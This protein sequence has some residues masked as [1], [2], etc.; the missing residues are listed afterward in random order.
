MKRHLGVAASLLLVAYLTAAD[1]SAVVVTLR[2]RA[3]VADARVTVG[4][5]AAVEGGAPALRQRITLL[6][7]ADLAPDRPN[8]VVSREQVAYRIR[9]AGIDTKLFRMEGAAQADLALERCQVTGPELETA[10]RQAIQRRLPWKPEDVDIVFVKPVPKV[11]AL[12]GAR[13]DIRL[14][15]ELRPGPLPLGRVH[16]DL[17]V[18]LRGERRQAVPVV[19]DVRAYQRVAVCTRRVERGETLSEANVT[20][21]RRA[22]Q[23][24]SSYVT[25]GDSLLGKRA[26]HALQ[27]GQVPTAHDVESA[28]PETPVLVKQREL[29]KLVAKLGPVHVSTMAEALQEGRDGQWIRVRNVESKKV[30]VGRVVA[31]ATVEVDH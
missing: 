19:L 14:E 18:Y 21:D 5:V 23:G 3:E 27:P 1:S 6:D 17:A 30:V 11:L 31:R 25:P 29:V 13:P 7:L 20:L 4:D 2:P 26:K 22:V 12:A 10:V 8:T 28:A 9:L 24:L 15:A 16:L